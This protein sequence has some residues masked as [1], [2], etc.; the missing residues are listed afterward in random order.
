MPDVQADK[1]PSP[2]RHTPATDVAAA[3]A[4]AAAALWGKPE[5]SAGMFGAAAAAA[6]AAVPPAVPRAA[7]PPPRRRVGGAVA[8]VSPLDMRLVSRMLENDGWDGC[9]P[10][11][12]VSPPPRRGGAHA[13]LGLL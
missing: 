9:I 6:A 2:P 8:G 13:H 11:S 3:T 1:L 10:A 12:P 5:P 7:P 4:A